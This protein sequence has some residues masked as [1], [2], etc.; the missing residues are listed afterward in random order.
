[1][2]EDQGIGATDENGFDLWR[3]WMVRGMISVYVNHDDLLDLKDAEN[4]CEAI[5]HYIKEIRGT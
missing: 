5:A 2:T 4:L 1:M 3:V